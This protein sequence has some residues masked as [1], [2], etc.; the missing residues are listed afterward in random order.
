MLVHP[1]VMR[2]SIGLRRRWRFR[3]GPGSDRRQRPPHRAQPSNT[4]EGLRRKADRK[5]QPERQQI[6]Q[7]RRAEDRAAAGFDP[8]ARPARPETARAPSPVRSGR[9]L[10]SRRS[11]RSRPVQALTRLHQQADAPVR[12]QGIRLVARCRIVRTPYC[13][14]PSRSARPARCKWPADDTGGEHSQAARPPARPAWPPRHS[15]G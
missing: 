7:R 11:G 14:R 4:A 3:A 2:Y 8:R 1:A 12:E 6:H 10:R 9:R 13:R 5:Q 15:G